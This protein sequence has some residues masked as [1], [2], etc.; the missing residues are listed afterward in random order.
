M[1]ERGFLGVSVDEILAAPCG[2]YCGACINRLIYKSCHGCGC[3]CG[4]CDATGHHQRC[5]IYQCCVEQRRLSDCSE[6]AEF[7]CTQLVQFCYNPVWTHHLPVLENLKRRKTVG[8]KRWL[9]E[10]KRFWENDWY[11]RAWLW[12]QRKCEEKLKEYKEK[13]RSLKE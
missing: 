11:R 8:V 4:N 7:P 13:S 2:L 10:Q 12:L 5:N 6:C 3:S 1:G 9:G